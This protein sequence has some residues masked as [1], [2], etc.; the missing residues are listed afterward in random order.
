MARITRLELFRYNRLM[1]TGTEHFVMDIHEMIQVLIGRNGS[2][3][4]SILERL[5]PSTPAHE[6]FY[7]GGYALLTI[8]HQGD[9]FVLKSTFNPKPHHEFLLNGENLNEGYTGRVQDKLIE[10]YFGIGKGIHDLLLGRI[11]FTE[12]TIADRKTWMMRLSPSNVD[13]LMGLFVWAKTQVNQQKGVINHL[14]QKLVKYTESRLGEETQKALTDRSD[15]LTQ[16]SHRVLMHISS[17]SNPQGLHQEAQQK[18]QQLLTRISQCSRHIDQVID[19]HGEVWQSFRNSDALFE[20]ERESAATLIAIQTQMKDHEQYRARLDGLLAELSQWEKL[21]QVDKEI[22]SLEAQR[23]VVHDECHYYLS[24]L[25]QSYPTFTV[26]PLPTDLLTFHREIT[27]TLVSL[28]NT[29]PHHDTYHPPRKLLEQHHE[30]RRSLQNT[31]TVLTNTIDQAQRYIHQYETAEHAECPS[32]KTLFRLGVMDNR[33]RKSLKAHKDAVE[34]R[35]ATE[36]QLKD[37]EK[38]MADLDSYVDQLNQLQLLIRT[39]PVYKSFWNYVTREGLFHTHPA[40]HAQFFE[41]YGLYLTTYHR[42]QA[43]DRQYQELI[44]LKTKLG[45]FNQQ[46]EALRQEHQRL[47]AQYQAYL[48]QKEDGFKRHQQLHRATDA[49]THV[50]QEIQ[51]LQQYQQT[52]HQTL[53]DITRYDLDH[54]LH[55]IHQELVME[56]SEITKTLKQQ[57]SVETLIQ[58]TQHQLTQAEEDLEGYQTLVQGLS[59]TEGLIAEQLSQSVEKICHKMNDVIQR[60]WSYDMTVEACHLDQGQLDYK[61]PLNI[62]KGTQRRKDVYEGSKGQKE[63]INLAFRIVAQYSLGLNHLPLYMD[64]PGQNFDDVHLNQYMSYIN[65]LVESQLFPQLFLISHDI[66]GYG[67]LSHSKQVVIDRSNI[68]LIEQGAVA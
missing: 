39:Y 31:L 10:Q 36:A 32:C 5:I 41:Q 1:L 21:E 63:I 18:I 4:S 38:T 9:T 25:Q 8:E 24:R 27:H 37:L 11:L 66:A 3:K 16:T 51:K 54:R 58:E 17:P 59:P 35:T 30:T 42:Y 57:H 53:I 23:Q 34:K 14:K 26:Q 43:L 7:P 61:F 46:P 49:I 64:E 40:S 33:Y 68:T 62:V 48:L 45:Q 6:D 2:G 12:M 20:A 19:Q 56:L 15:A 22:V 50:A 60:C 47:E 67:A 44:Q 13:Y 29:L 55:Q 65:Q 28:F 52:L